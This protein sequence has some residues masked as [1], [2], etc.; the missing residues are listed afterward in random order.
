M[1]VMDDQIHEQKSI[2]NNL[3]LVGNWTGSHGNIPLPVGTHKVD[4]LL[5]L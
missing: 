4:C 2:K 1:I 5:V 3:T